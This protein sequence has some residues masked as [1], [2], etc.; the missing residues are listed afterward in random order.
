LESFRKSRQHYAVLI[1]EYGTLQGVITLDDIVDALVGDVSAEH[2][3]E[4]QITEVDPNT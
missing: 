1:D 2:H 4:Y 3:D